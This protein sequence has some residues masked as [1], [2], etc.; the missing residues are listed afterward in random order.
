MSPGTSGGSSSASR[1]SSRRATPAPRGSA[2]L[3]AAL[4]GLD[5]NQENQDQNLVCY[6]LHHRVKNNGPRILVLRYPKTNVS[7]DEDRKI[8][9]SG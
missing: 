7:R 3:T 6:R 4:P 1:T 2:V 8:G 5:S 9:R